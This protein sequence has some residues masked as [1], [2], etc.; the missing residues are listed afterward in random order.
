MLR[1]IVV[2]FIVLLSF[3][4]GF[5][6][7]R[8]YLTEDEVELVRVNQSI[9]TRIDILIHAIDRR[10]AVLALQPGATEKQKDGWG[11]LPTGTRAQLLDD[12]KL[13]LRKAIDDIDNVA[14]RPDSVVVENVDTGKKNKTVAE[15]LPTAI[16]RLAAASGRYRP[17]LSAELDKT[18]D[19]AEKGILMDSIAMC[20][21]VIAAV[22]KL[23]ASVKPDAKAKNKPRLPAS[24]R[25]Q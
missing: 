4:G 7:N 21:D 8:D 11:P 12:L 10:M 1:L 20:D 5:A 23:P 22:A 6:Q 25:L 13:I 17:L 16:R 24:E 9:D 14:A 18:K 15:L 3:V 2:S 19:S